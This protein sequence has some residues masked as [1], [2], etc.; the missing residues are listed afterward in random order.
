MSAPRPCACGPARARV[1]PPVA[2]GEPHRPRVPGWRTTFLTYSWS[3]KLAR[4]Q[5]LS[6]GTP[7][8]GA[9]EP[10]GPVLVT[11]AQPAQG[12]LP[13]LATV[14][15][16]SDSR[17]DLK[18][19]ITASPLARQ[20][21]HLQSET[22]RVTHWEGTPVRAS[23]SPVLALHVTWSLGRAEQ[24]AAATLNPQTV[25]SWRWLSWATGPSTPTHRGAH[26]QPSPPTA[27]DG[28]PVSGHLRV[29]ETRASPLA[30]GAFSKIV[31]Y[32]NV[33]P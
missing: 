18:C 28:G 15:S 5:G 13:G 2:S 17:R 1:A 14:S 30:E 3:P 29:G 26:L 32:R 23:V 10:A 22:E 31:F 21:I 24:P 11:T 6:A 27:C 8:S 19:P 7:S 20:R 12:S 9:H 4:P 33:T 16:S 25:G